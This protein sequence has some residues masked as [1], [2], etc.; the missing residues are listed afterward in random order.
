MDSG[1][2]KIQLKRIILNS[3]FQVPFY[4]E[5][6]TVIVNVLLLIGEQLKLQF[7]TSGFL[8]PNLGFLDW[9]FEHWNIL[10]Q[11]K[12]VFRILC[13][14]KQ[15]SQS[16]FLLAQR[17]RFFFVYMTHNCFFNSWEKS[18]L[19]EQKCLLIY[20]YNRSVEIIVS[21]FLIFTSL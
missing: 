19:Y 11:F 9:N 21:I 6:N 4:P 2:P 7:L 18:M 20:D 8:L 3:S 17:Y 13:S 1:E 5:T 10:K 15:K 12:R 16:F 14:L